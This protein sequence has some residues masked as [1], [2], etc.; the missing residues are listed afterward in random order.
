MMEKV[1]KDIGAILADKA[2]VDEA[3]RKARRH[4]ILQHRQANQ[5]MVVYR[6][7]EIVWLEPSQLPDIPL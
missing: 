1:S 4:A 6:N 2:K 3:I 5:P 7:G